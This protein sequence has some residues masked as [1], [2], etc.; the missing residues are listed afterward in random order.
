[1]QASFWGANS[2]TGPLWLVF[3]S[4]EVA[5]YPAGQEFGEFSFLAVQLAQSGKEVFTQGNKG[6]KFYLYQV[7]ISPQ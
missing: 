3:C 5:L 6:L 2:E 7:S 4:I 1:M